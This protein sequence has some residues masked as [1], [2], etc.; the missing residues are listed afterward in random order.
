MTIY[1]TGDSWS[2]QGWPGGYELGY[3]T[4][5]CLGAQLQKITT[6]F[7]SVLAEHGDSDFNQFANMEKRIDP[8]HPTVIVHGWSDWGRSLDFCWDNKNFTYGDPNHL[9]SY[10]SARE[11]A[12]TRV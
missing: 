9:R 12:H 2:S 10:D 8:K 6:R 3:A 4:H 11:V 7:V 1:V 5:E